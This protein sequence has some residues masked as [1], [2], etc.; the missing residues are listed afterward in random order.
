MNY[1]EIPDSFNG[2]YIIINGEN[3]KEVSDAIADV[4]GPAEVFHGSDGSVVKAPSG[5]EVEKALCMDEEKMQQSL[6]TLRNAYPNVMFNEED[7]EF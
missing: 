7:I 6:E 1:D 3:H 2:P 4:F 5:S